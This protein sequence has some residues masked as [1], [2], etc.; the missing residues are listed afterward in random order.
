[1]KFF[2][3]HYTDE[4]ADAEDISNYVTAAFHKYNPEVIMTSGCTSLAPGDTWESKLIN[5][6][7]EA[8][9]L[10]VLVS[11]DALTRP[12]INFAIGVAWAKSTPVLFLC[13]K[14]MDP[15]A[16]PGPYGS[17]E[18]INL[19]GLTQEV[20]LKHICDAVS[21]VLA[22]EAD[23]CDRIPGLSVFE[24]VESFFSVYRRWHLRPAAHIDET[25]AGLFLVGAV[26]ASHADRAL[27]AGL[28]PDD[29]LFVRLFLKGSPEGT[30]I[31]AMVSGKLANFFEHVVSDT[32][33][34]AKIR[35]AAALKA[36]EKTTPLLVIDNVKEIVSND[37]QKQSPDRHPKLI[38]SRV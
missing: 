31:N 22:I 27:L 24:P 5:A 15:K 28:T 17:L 23:D 14:G 33:I 34:V 20:K 10:L 13:H 11:F 37:M 1:M 36:G 35:C 30:Y 19:N 21:S 9:L 29:T 3:S 26:R 6:V 8:N 4:E 16:L 32:R 12:L 7:N 25:A 38:K 18:S 2:I